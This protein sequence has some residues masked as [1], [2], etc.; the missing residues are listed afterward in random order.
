MRYPE[1]PMICARINNCLF[2]L[3]INQHARINDVIIAPDDASHDFSSIRTSFPSFRG[4]PDDFDTHFA[5]FR[6][7]LKHQTGSNDPHVRIMR[8]SDTVII[9]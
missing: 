7:V 4:A 9:D 5:A 3:K 6:E 1:G 2:T 8:C